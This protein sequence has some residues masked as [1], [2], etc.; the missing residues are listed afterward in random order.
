MKRR[1]FVTGFAGLF[2]A[3]LAAEAQPAGNVRVP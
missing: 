3:P 1:V 2:V